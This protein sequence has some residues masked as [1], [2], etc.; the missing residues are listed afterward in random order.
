MAGKHVLPLELRKYPKI[1][2]VCAL[3]LHMNQLIV[4]ERCTQRAIQA[5]LSRIALTHQSPIV[6]LW[7]TISVWDKAIQQC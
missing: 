4:A 3:F 6:T 2:T 1:R 7:Y 5:Q